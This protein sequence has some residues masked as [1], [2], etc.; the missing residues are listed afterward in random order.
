MSA[1]AE[2]WARAHA[3]TPEASRQ[4]PLTTVIIAHASDEIGPR[5]RAKLRSSAT[6][7]I[8]VPTAMPPDSSHWD[9]PA[10][11]SI[12]RALLAAEGRTLTA[13]ALAMMFYGHSS[14][15]KRE[16]EAMAEAGLLER[17]PPGQREPGARGRPVSAVYFL[18]DASAEEVRAREEDPPVPTGLVERGLQVVFA[19]QIAP[20]LE[21]LAAGGALPN[22]SWF[23]L[24]DGEP[25]EYAIAFAGAEAVEWAADLMAELR[26]A[27][28][29]ARR[30]T[31]TEVLPIERLTQRARRTARAAQKSRVSRAT[32]E[33]GTRQAS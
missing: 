22:A 28:L 27:E 2:L 16:C 25:Q 33:T 31:I 32:R 8:R 7:G 20:L 18:P 19:E 1:P 11:L 6:G 10:W 21:A 9:R 26:G 29:R 5:T 23:A 12:G 24:C 30:A 13:P 3:T 15:Y 14:N 4:I 17:R